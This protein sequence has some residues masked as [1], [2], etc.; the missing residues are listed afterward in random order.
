MGKVFKARPLTYAV[1]V[2]AV[3]GAVMVLVW[4][5]HF[6]GGTAW[7]STDKA[8]I[9]NLHPVITLIGYIILG[10]EA[11]IAFKAFPLKKEKKKVIHMV[12]HAVALILGILGIYTAFKFHN[13]AGIAN[14]Y[15][16]HAWLGMAAIVLYAIQW[17]YG[18][19]IFFYPGGSASLRSVSV[20]WHV[21]LGMLAYSLA[22]GA[23][24]LGFM[25]KMT[26]LEIAGI[27]KYGPEAYLVNFT[28]AATVLY[29][30]FVIFAVYGEGDPPPPDE[31]SYIAI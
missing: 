19:V 1:H 8:L 28:A 29:G 26:Y 6:R 27:A 21:I 7:E 31:Y 22:V 23:A 11:T 20:P 25:E 3:A 18:F 17:A 13:E 9:F 4:T 12:L 30:A 5:Y 24:A 16:F 10:G 14:L 2:L 15:S